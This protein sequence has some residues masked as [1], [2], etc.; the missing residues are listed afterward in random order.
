MKIHIFNP[1]NDMALANGTPG[2]TPPAN[3]RKYR[4]ANWRLPEKWASPDDIIWDGETHFNHLGILPGQDYEIFPWGWSPAIVHQL[5]LAGFPPEK[6]PSAHLLQKLRTLSSRQT[7]VSIQR[8]FGLEAYVCHTIDEI[9]DI[10]HRQPRRNYI[11]KSPW[12]SSGKGIMTPENANWTGWVRQVLRLQ[13]AVIVERKL[14]RAQDFA[15][16]FM[17]DENNNIKYL[18]LSL[19]IT[20]E[21]GHYLHNILNPQKTESLTPEV[22]KPILE[23]Y[24]TNLPRIA[25]WYYGPIG[26]DML[27]TTTGEICPCIEINWRMTMGI[28]TLL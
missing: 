8:Q 19:F 10:M 4:Q 1:E 2:Y 5:Q 14:E 28:A 12:S 16:E 13:G 15:M 11:L 3:I 17:K 22:L 25:P 21:Y 24:L 18:G 6:M 27:I 20:D 9:M 7:T 23:W 26:V